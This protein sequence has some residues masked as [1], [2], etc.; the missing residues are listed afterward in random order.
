VP[1]DRTP[2]DAA[3]IKRWFLDVPDLEPGVF[4]FA[5]VLGGTV[6][7]GAYTAGAVDFL[8]E[9]LDCLSNAQ[10]QDRAPKHT[11]R[12]KLIAG[13]SGGGVNA[14]IAARILAYDYPHV[15]R[16]TPIGANGSGNPFYDVWVNTLRLDRFLDTSDIGQQLTSLLNGKLIDDGAAAIIAFAN[17]QPRARDWVAEPLRII[18]TLTGLVPDQFRRQAEPGL[19][20][21]CRL[22][23]FRP[24]LPWADSWRAQAGRTGA[25]FRRR[26]PASGNE[27]E[28]V[29]RICP[30]HG[31][32]SNRLPLARAEPANR[33]LSLA[34]GRLSAGPGRENRLP[35]E[36]AGLGRDGPARRH[37][38]AR[39]VAVS[40]GRRGRDRQR[41]D[42]ACENRTRRSAEP[43]STWLGQG[44]PG[45]LADRPI[46]PGRSPL[47]PKGATTFPAELGAVATT[48]TQQTRTTPPTCSWPPTT[49]FS[50]A[51]C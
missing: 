27:L 17:G 9:A 1:I 18:L 11:V 33:A 14:A 35:S 25:G 15:R 26:A 5:L 2:P 10:L 31:G 34:C 22:R 7:A 42:R 23:A 47:G 46:R 29:Q 38:G 41:A 3:Q 39:R 48:L 36:L 16:A 20:R 21:S 8:I 32:V 45:G 19:C 28:A 44:Q 50:A 4:E 13:T 40:R 12:L 43:Q 30:C 24:A 51:S 6:S 49:R 37:R